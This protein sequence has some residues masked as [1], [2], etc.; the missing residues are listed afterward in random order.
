[1]AET[2]ERRVWICLR[3]GGPMTA[4]AIAK[5]LALTLKQVHHALRRMG[6]L[7][8]ADNYSIIAGSAPPVDGRPLNGNLAKGR[9]IGLAKMARRKK[10]PVH[11]QPIPKIALEQA[12]GWMSS[13]LNDLED[14]SEAA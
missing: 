8:S 14:D 10:P 5:T 13:P 3:N 1:M 12:W 11:P 2:I 7:R 6:L 9:A 4:Q